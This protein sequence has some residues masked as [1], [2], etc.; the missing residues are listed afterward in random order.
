[1]ETL[2]P[3]GHFSE[4]VGIGRYIVKDAEFFADKGS[5]SIEGAPGGLSFDPAHGFFQRQ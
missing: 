3:G 5:V 2:S 4:F 1:M